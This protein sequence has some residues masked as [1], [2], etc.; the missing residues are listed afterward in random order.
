MYRRLQQEKRTWERYEDEILRPNSR[1]IKT[2]NPLTEGYSAHPI[3]GTDMHEW[4]C[5]VPGAPETKWE[6]GIYMLKITFAED[7]PFRPPVIKFL[8]PNCIP[9]SAEF[10]F[11]HPNASSNNEFLRKFLR[12][13]WCAM[14]T[15][16]N[17][18]REIQLI[19]AEPVL[20]EPKNHQMDQPMRLRS[21]R[22]VRFKR[23]DNVPIEQIRKPYF[24]NNV[25]YRDFINNPDEYERKV[26]IQ[27]QQYS[28]T[29]AA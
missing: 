6:G 11:Y 25:A 29:D 17:L 9:P 4:E 15:I 19:L 13:A 14:L 23:D 28:M 27:A 26:R 18:L 3:E 22:F 2:E 10:Q 7:N 24:E 5:A 12:D 1:R 21:G 8:P 16:E 20:D